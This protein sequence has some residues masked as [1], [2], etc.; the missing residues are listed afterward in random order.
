MS[1]KMKIAIIINDDAR[2]IKLKVK[3][4]SAGYEMYRDYD[5]YPSI[6]DDKK[7]LINFDNYETLLIHKTEANAD[8]RGQF[9]AYLRAFKGSIVLF[10]GDIEN[11]IEKPYFSIVDN[12]FKKNLV[13]FL[14]NYKKNGKPNL[15]DFIK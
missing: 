15:Y 13:S 14:K 1:K 11:Y 5:S 9:N 6:F 10:S 3:F 2:W 4:T 8:Y 12:Y 7:Q